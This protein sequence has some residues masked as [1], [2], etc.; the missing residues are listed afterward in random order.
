M[1][2]SSTA[3]RYA[4]AAFAVAQQDGDIQSWIADLRGVAHA[5]EE[6]Q[7]ARFFRDPNVP[8]ES[9][10]AAVGQLFGA[11]PPHVLNLL[12]ILTVRQRM[13]LVPAI[14]QEL[15]KL[16]RQARG[17]VDASVTVARPVD[18]TEREEIA[19]GLSEATGKQVTVHVRVDPSILGGIVVRLGDR[20]LDAS[21][22]G[23]LERLRQQMAV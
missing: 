5:L 21:V 1:R 9:K 10:M 7:T 12:R 16:D 17:I 3:R 13:Y 2:P 18:E 6:E 22:A 8:V 20:L 19:R 23:R 11:V 15:E 14:L 4:D